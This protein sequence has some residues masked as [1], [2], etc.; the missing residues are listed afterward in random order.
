MYETNLQLL[1]QRFEKYLSRH[2]YVC[3]GVDKLNLLKSHCDTSLSFTHLRMNG[4]RVRDGI[5]GHQI[6]GSS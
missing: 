3:I 4:L 5:A 6:N 1:L 2:P